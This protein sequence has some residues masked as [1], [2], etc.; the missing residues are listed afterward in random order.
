M[1]NPGMNIKHNKQRGEWAE[2]RF[3]TRAT[4]HGLKV[5]KPWGDSLPYDF[6][7]ESDGTFV[8]VQ[9]KSTTYKKDGAYR[10][11]IHTSRGPYPNNPFDFVAA[12]IVP[13][14]LWYI[15]PIKLARGP[16]CKFLIPPHRPQ[17][18]YH[19]YREA[20]HLLKL[21]RRA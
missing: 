7:V 1:R 4:E 20:W 18:K 2:M 21:R 19:P 14:D 9:V 8:R 16:N 11:A 15:I 12:Y 13:L 17:S 3:M 6:A 10:C 5:T